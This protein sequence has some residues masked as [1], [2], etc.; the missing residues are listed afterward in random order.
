MSAKKEREKRKFIKEINKATEAKTFE[1]LDDYFA[2][3]SRYP[4]RVR[5][6]M[7]WKIVFKKFGKPGNGA[8]K[9]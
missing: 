3:V 9:L 7:A 1:I 6:K 5:F 4:F 8:I 2:A